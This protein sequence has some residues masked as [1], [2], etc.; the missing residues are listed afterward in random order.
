M[1][2][3]VKNSIVLKLHY[4]INTI[5]YI[6]YTYNIK[7]KNLSLH[8]SGSQEVQFGKSSKRILGLALISNI[9]LLVGIF[10]Q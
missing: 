5:I 1:N 3:F 8:H 9:K 6:Y 2:Q 10:I 7:E 4:I